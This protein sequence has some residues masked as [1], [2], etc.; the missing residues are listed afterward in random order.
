MKIRN[1]FVSN[2]SSSSFI[3]AINQLTEDQI[4]K[5][6]TYPA[7]CTFPGEWHSTDEFGK[8]YY[9][10]GWNIHKNDSGGFITGFTIMDNGDLAKYMTEEC[11]I[12]LKLVEWDDE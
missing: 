11:G 5:L 10:D 4:E 3:V 8:Y 7:E 1:G 12:D 6:M 2:S 9:G